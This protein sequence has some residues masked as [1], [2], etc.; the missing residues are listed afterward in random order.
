MTDQLLR[1]KEARKIIP[2]ADKT[3][4]KYIADGEL[5]AVKMGKLLCIWQS[6]AEAFLRN[7]PSASKE[8][9]NG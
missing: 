5:K 3:I 7:Q 9:D 4:R 6:D 1:L 8:A 2:L